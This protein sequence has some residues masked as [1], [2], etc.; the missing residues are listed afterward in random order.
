[1]RA[2]IYQAGNICLIALTHYAALAWLALLAYVFGRRLTARISYQSKLEEICFSLV[3]GLSAIAYLIFLLGLLH[4]LYA[5]TIAAG[6]ALGLICCS[7]LWRDWWRSR[8]T[9]DLS[10]FEWRT[11]WQRWPVVFGVALTLPILLL[12]LY[13]PT[14][15]DAIEWHLASAKLYLEQHALVFAPYLRYPVFPQTNQMLFAGALLFFDDLFAQLIELL[16]FATLAASVLAFGKR[17]LSARAGWWAAALLLSSPIVIWAG[18]VAYVDV[19]LMLYIF[20]GGYAF[21]NWVTARE[22]DWLV[23]TGVILGLAV[24]V[25]Y[26]ALFFVLLFGAVALLK[27]RGGERITAPLIIGGISLLVAGPWLARNFYYTRNPVFPYYYEIFAPLFG[28]GEWSRE[29]IGDLL[30][31]PPTRGVGRSL[32]GLLSLPWQ[33]TF[34]VGAFESE[35]GISRLYILLLPLAAVVAIWRRSTRWLLVLA[36]SYTLFW[37]GTYQILRYLLPALPFFCLAAGDALNVICR[38]LPAKRWSTA[39]GVVLLIWPGWGYAVRRV[40]WSGPPPSNIGARDLYLSTQLP[41]YPLYQFLNREHGRDYSLYAL[42]SENM[43]YY[44]DGR[45]MGDWFGP[46]SYDRVLSQMTN[47]E[48]LYQAVRRFGARYFLVNFSRLNLKLPP[49]E[50]ARGRFQPLMIRSQSALYDLSDNPS[51]AIIGENLLANPGFE[52]LLDNRPVGW[53][54]QGNP[55][56]DRSGAKRLSGQA[57]AY[58]ATLTDVFCQ[59]VA[60]HAGR[61]YRMGYAAQ[62]EPQTLARLH[63]NWFESSG[64]LIGSDI[65]IV[66]VGSELKRYETDLIAPAGVAYGIVYISPQSTE[67]IWFD[68]AFFAEVSFRKAQ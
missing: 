13:P 58:A 64:K 16:L 67:R 3:L 30:A 66:N 14:Q 11:L 6:L 1:M 51:R 68:D 19:G 2:F 21:W 40:Y 18:V 10:A 54:V 39:L 53:M 63:V 34:N 33:L 4:L 50:F 35:A 52:E 8:P 37:W 15:W 55:Q 60:V 36:A 61:V 45:M 29:Y 26:P 32:K 25:K 57:S 47:G 62:A 44:A 7:P 23:M 42:G 20:V 49:D 65:Q 56:V 28:Y 38:R 22:R 9:F 59:K 17:Y 31:N 12:P 24:S 27:G 5:G 48:S 46:A 43:Y 41:S